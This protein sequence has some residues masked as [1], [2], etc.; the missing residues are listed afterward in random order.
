MR[1]EWRKS[2]PRGRKGKRLEDS[3]QGSRDG[4]R[5]KGRTDN[6]TKEAMQ[7]E[8]ERR[9]KGSEDRRRKGQTGEKEGRTGEKKG[10]EKREDRRR[11]G[12]KDKTRGKEERM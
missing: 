4:L 6:E 1:K 7:I 2:H 3:R 5:E 10:Q 11:K 12:R 8:K 9:R